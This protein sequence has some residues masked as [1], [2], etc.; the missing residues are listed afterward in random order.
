MA[1]IKYCDMEDCNSD[2]NETS[3]ITVSGDLYKALVSYTLLHDYPHC[4]ELDVCTECIAIFIED[5]AV[6]GD[7]LRELEQIVA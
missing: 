7:L 6:T 3:I 2:D 1:T 4:N 5:K